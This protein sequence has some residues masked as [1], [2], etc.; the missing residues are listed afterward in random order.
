M[1]NID[2]PILALNVSGDP[3]RWCSYEDAAYYY[4]KDLVAWSIGDDYTLSGGIQRVSGERSTMK[5]ESIIAIKGKMNTKRSRIPRL[6]NHGLFRRDM[7]LCG[8]C[9]QQYVNAKLTRDHVIPRTQNGANRWGNVVTACS[10]CNK[11]KGGRTP[12]QANMELLYIPY[13][14]CLN[15]YLILMN[16]RILADQMDYLVKNVKN[17]DSRIH[18]IIQSLKG[19]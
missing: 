4:A 19:D 6:T 8:Y 3:V 2:S 5:I 14:P 12:E 1:I 7:N 9:G 15:E 17:E 16:R 13:V 10:P 18:Q 11:H